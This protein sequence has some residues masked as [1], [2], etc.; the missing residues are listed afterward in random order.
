MQYSPYLRAWR[1]SPLFSRRLTTA[2]SRTIGHYS[3]N[4]DYS[5]EALSAYLAEVDVP[6]LTNKYRGKLDKCLLNRDDSKAL[7]LMQPG[8]TPDGIS[9]EFY[10][11]YP[12]VLTVRC[13][14]M[15]T[16]AADLQSH[17]NS[18]GKA[19]I[20]VIPKPGKDSSLSSSYRPISLINVDAKIL[21]KILAN[22]LNA[23]IAALIHPNQTGLM[24]GR[25]TNI[26]IRRLF[27]HTARAAWEGVLCG[28]EKAFDSIK[29]R[30]IWAVLSKYGFGPKF[31]LWIKMLY[32]NSQARVY[33]NACLS[34]SFSLNHGT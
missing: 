20:V 26:N 3:S 23:V 29:W 6:V 25:G 4:V 24:A 1:G 10:K 27:T 9:I 5:G 22:R 28:Q 7:K 31:Q 18:M 11:Q 12:D 33:T 16:T 2:L 15:M 14:A 17:P 8:K 13:R 21:A 34:D 30:Y 19:V 32:A